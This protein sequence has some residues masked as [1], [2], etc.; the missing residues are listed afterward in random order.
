MSEN[1]C[2]EITLISRRTMPAFPS[3][4]YS[5]FVGD[6]VKVTDILFIITYY[7]Y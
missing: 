3:A 6:I 4:L 7:K 2:I 1:F 5:Q